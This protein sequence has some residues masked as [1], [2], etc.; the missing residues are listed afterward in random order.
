MIFSFLSHLGF[1]A[2]RDTSGKSKNED[3]DATRLFCKWVIF[4]YIDFSRHS[5]HVRKLKLF[6]LLLWIKF[7]LSLFSRQPGHVVKFGITENADFSDFSFL[8]EIFRAQF[9]TSL[10]FSSIRDTFE[11]ESSKRSEVDF[12]TC[13]GWR[14]NEL[15]QI[16]RDFL[17]V[18]LHV[19]G[20]N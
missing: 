9:F 17:C 14:E 20:P 18:N 12:L 4:S 13:A 11:K 15:V 2:I 8:F 3:D 10:T 19:F 7:H 6:I 1:P 16:N 5:G